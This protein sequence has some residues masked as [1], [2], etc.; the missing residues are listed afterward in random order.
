[1]TAPSPGRA[2][3]T[4]AAVLALAVAVRVA[5]IFL[6]PPLVDV[7]Y[8]DAQAV[9][10]L[11]SGL[12]PYGHLYSGIPAWLA[13][14]GAQNVYAYLPGVFLFLFPFGAVGDVRFGLVAAD[15]AVAAGLLGLG[16][17]RARVA[18]IAFFLAPWAFLFS[19]S[20]PNNTLV[21]M[22]FLGG[23][24]VA[25]TRGR[26]LVASVSLGAALASSQFVWLVYPFLL[27]RYL[28]RR[29]PFQAALSL[30]VGF[31]V[32]LPFAL[33]DY[34]SFVY[35]AVFFQ[36]ARPVQPLV[37]PETFGLNFNPTLS[38]LVFTAT[39]LAVPLAAR[40]LLA[41]AALAY[42]LLRTKGWSELLFSASA[43]VLVAVFVLAD[44]FSWWYLELPFQTL[45][46]GYALRGRDGPD[47]HVNA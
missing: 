13:T 30:L 19:T 15:L 37:T 45:L 27:A 2:S 22:A 9:T 47:G 43:F 33:W 5:I 39:G 46:A 36:F 6:V 41:A 1:M 34:G 7:Y 42:L 14:Q 35:D 4:V 17:A 44:D 11:A 21:A 8:Y 3:Q 28:R 25:E 10:A 38:G 24:L 16:G 40:A 12:D 32:V 20:Y 26:S 31:L 29:M 18:S 23:Y